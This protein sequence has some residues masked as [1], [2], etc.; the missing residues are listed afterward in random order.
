MKGD[1]LPYIKSIVR[2][3]RDWG[4]IRQTSPAIAGKL[5]QRLPAMESKKITGAAAAKECGMALST[6][7]CRAAICGNAGVL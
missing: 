6:F 7:R 5:P 1:D 3:G 2:P 4:K